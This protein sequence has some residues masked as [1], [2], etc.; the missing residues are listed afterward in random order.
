MCII[1]Y[2]CGAALY[3]Q[4]EAVSIFFV[5]AGSTFLTWFLHLLSGLAARATATDVAKCVAKDVPYFNV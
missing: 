1:H 2:A 5:T 4:R 3:A